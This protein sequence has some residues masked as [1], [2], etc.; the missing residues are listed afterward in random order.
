MRKVILS[1]MTSLDGSIAKPD[2]DINW[3]RTDAG[4]EEEML[5]LLH[6]VDVML[7]GRVS[8]Q[9]L[10]EFWPT[11]GQE[12]SGE[13]PGGFTTKAREQEFATLMNETPKIVYSRTLTAPTWGPVRVVRDGIAED[14]ARM[15]QEPGK[16][17]VLFAGA[18]IGTT[19]INLDLVDQYRLMIHPVIISRGIDLFGNVAA[20]RPLTLSRT[21]TFDC[22][23]ILLQYDRDRGATS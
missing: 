10:A 21:R 15:K 13:A 14:L 5:T 7:F 9:L 23:V 18:N 1:M 12:A 16:D 22:G 20:E 2:G 8:Y 11:A 17:I 6:S 4:F 3:F 19:F